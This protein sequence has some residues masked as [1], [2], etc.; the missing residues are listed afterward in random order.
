MFTDMKL[1][2]IF[3]RTMI[4][5][6]AVSTIG[7]ASCNYLDIVP[8]EQVG[9]DDAMENLTNATGFLY[10]CYNPMTSTA[11]AELPYRFY[12]SDLVFANDDILN[13]HGWATDGGANG[14]LGYIL[15]NTLS[16]EINNPVW[17]HY[18]KGIGQC[19]LFIEKM[20]KCNIVGRGIIDE[21][22]AKEWRAEAKALIAYY[23]FLL[24]RRYGP[25]VICDSRVSMGTPTSD[26][27]GRCH[28]DYCVDWIAD[29]LDEAAYDLPAVRPASECGRM[30]VAICKAIKAQMYLLAASP[31]WNGQFP[32]ANFRN[33]NFETP[34]YGLELVSRTYDK[35]KWQRAYDA[36]DEAIK[37]AEKEGN[38]EI[39]TDN[40]HEKSHSLDDLWVPGNVTDDFKRAVLRM[41][42]LY[43][44]GQGEGNREAVWEMIQDN[45]Y[46]AG[47]AWLHNPAFPPNM[48]ETNNGIQS[49][50]GGLNPTLNA[51]T[52]FLTKDGYLP[53]ND[54]NFTPEANWFKSAGLPSEGL[55]R[56]RIINLHV[57]RE[58]RFYAWIGFDG[59]D[60]GLYLV[61]GEPVH[62]NLMQNH[63]PGNPSDVVGYHGYQSRQ[64]DNCCTGYLYQ[65]HQPATIQINPSG[66]YMNFTEPTIKIIRLSE[67]YLTRA[68]CAAQLD[69]TPQALK[70]VNVIR[71]R[72]GVPDL[73][74]EMIGVGGM[75]LLD[76]VLNERRVEFFAEAHR[77]F[78]IRRYVAGEKY[79]GYGKRMG[80]NSLE[81]ENPT[82]E[83]FNKP[84]SLP[85]PYTWGNKLYLYP[86]P[87][88]EVYANPQCVQNPGY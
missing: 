23:H 13:P 2:N 52:H 50:N 77:Y 27:K 21:A 88:N 4:S 28:F 25:I 9:V 1:K 58:P 57:N 29:Q 36:V 67:L 70:D 31:L 85:Y 7:L 82:F 24:L 59:G 81:R 17:T 3:T 62:L 32:Y 64:R 75:S 54:P 65:K 80:L 78:D 68:E 49:G 47:T 87:A 61:N 15:L 72:A 74:S 71:S 14:Y 10:S 46:Y 69:N 12:L 42:Y 60:L 16:A 30:T 41:R 34:G 37:Y 79:L 6:M 8:P 55:R 76:W 20:D 86:V 35:S 73:T 40:Y 33:V 66:G 53:E 83:E 39:Y 44:T 38:C 84:I 56:D 11:S 5:F 63:N 43:C 19:L 22:K 48:M 45:D 26:Y 51:V 18:Y